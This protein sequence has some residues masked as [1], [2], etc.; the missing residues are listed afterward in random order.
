MIIEMYDLDKYFHFYYVTYC[1][2]NFW[3]VT[4]LSYIILNSI[5][6]PFFYYAILGIF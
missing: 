4:H 1:L 6:I 5:L 3:Y 2:S